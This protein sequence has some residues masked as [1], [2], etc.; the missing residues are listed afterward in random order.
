MLI[1]SN[2]AIRK[3]CHGNKFKRPVRE[4]ERQVTHTQAGTIYSH[5]RSTHAVLLQEGMLLLLQHCASRN[6]YMIYTVALRLPPAPRSFDF[7][8]ESAA[9]VNIFT[10]QRSGYQVLRGEAKRLA[11][12][13]V[14]TYGCECQW[15]KKFVLL[16]EDRD[17]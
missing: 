1:I 15:R 3:A 12:A 7:L 10:S 13:T 8:M 4:I 5:V 17:R 2:E 14:S 6:S 11:L 16:S 9:I